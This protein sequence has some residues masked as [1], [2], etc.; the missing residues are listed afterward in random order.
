[1]DDQEA[2]PP[3]Q[4]AAMGESLMA[5]LEQARATGADTTEIEGQLYQ[6]QQMLKEQEERA[7]RERQDRLARLGLSL[8]AELDKRRGERQVVELRWMRDT[9]RY[10]SEYE[11]DKAQEMAARKYGS[12]AFVPLTRRV[13]NV[14]EARLG[15]LLFPVDDTNFGVEPSPVPQLSKA[16]ELAA[17]MPEDQ[18]VDAGGEQIPASAVKMAVGEMLDKARDAAAAMQKEI[19]DQLAESDFAS[20]ARAAIR[21]GLVIGMG[22]IKGPTL[23][24]R[25]RKQWAEVSGKMVLQMVEDERPSAARVDPWLFFPETA[26]KS[27]KECGSAFE[28]HPMS[29]AEFAALARQPGF[30]KEAIRQELEGLPNYTP[31]ANERSTQEAAG[32]AGIPVQKYMVWEYHGPIDRTDLEACG[33]E[34]PDDELVTYSGVVFFTDRGR[35][36][37]AIV[38]VMQS[39]AIPYHTWSWQPDANSIYGYGLSYELGDVQDAANASWRGGLD[40]MGLSVGGQLVI[41]QQAIKPQN[42]SYAIEPNKVWFKTVPGGRVEDVFKLFEIPSRIQ[43]LM[44]I[45]NMAKQLADEIGGPML[46]MQGQDAP[47]YM[48]TAQG[49]SI[50]YN[51]ASVWMRRGVKNW[52][53]FMT[54]P[55]VTQFVDWNMEHNPKDEIKGDM[56]PIAR[57]ASHLLEAEG[58]VQRIQ[59][60]MQMAQ[61]MGIPLRKAVNQLRAMCRAMRLDDRDLLP[62]DEEIAEMEK[63]QAAQQPQKS[64]EQERLEIR[65]MELQDRQQEREHQAMLTQQTN[66]LRMAELAQKE[67][68]TV[69]QTRAKYELEMTKLQANLEDRREER[70]LKAQ[71][72]NAELASRMTTGAGV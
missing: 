53:D 71:S 41:D 50:A 30:D 55:M 37:K 42:G 40:N 29:R 38:N 63:Q 43:E 57:G 64:P 1:M 6:L 59:L 22:V 35:V 46:A 11:P 9:R 39:G 68:L 24:M 58:Q 54:I 18:P 19:E 15:D 52:D 3:E 17:R 5:A 4:I 61:G 45:F 10:N 34:L 67:G 44:A 7:A 72:L 65:Q 70:A 31:D 69:E 56:R 20:E 25:M 32:V 2:L 12:R 16:A 36:L 28:G 13:V 51:S 48:Q 66:Q 27:M 23:Y 60:L 14:I 49:M 21:D 62:S 47:S 8:K 26:A 33:C